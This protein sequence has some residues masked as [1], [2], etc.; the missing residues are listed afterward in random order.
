MT[1]TRPAVVLAVLCA[2]DFLVV[3][4]GLIVA[5]A[6][7]AM[8]DALGIAPSALQWVINA[9]LLGFGGLL[10][11]GG[12]LGDLYGRR[13][14]LTGG[15]VLFAAGALAG[16]LA[17][18]TAV[19]IAGRA[20]QGAA[21]ALMAPNALALLVEHFREPAERD[22]ALGRWSAVGSLGIPAGALLG[23]VITAGL[24]W[25]WVL[26]VNV[27]LAL[28]AAAAT[29]RVL[30]ESRDPGAGRRLDLPGA[31]LVTAGTTLLILAVVR[32]EAGARSVLA[33]LTGGVLLM[34]AFAAV[35]RRARAPLV[36]PGTLGAPG[37]RPALLAGAALPV[38]LGA[39]LFLGTLYLQRGLGLAPLE[40]GL[41]Y[42][43]LALP[44]IAASPAAARLS[45][46]YGARPVAVAGLLLQAA[47]LLLLARAPADGSFA[48]D[49][50]PA[51]VLVGAGAP[52][53]FVP[54]TAAIM[55]KAGEAS[56]LVSG[57]FNTAQQIGNALALAVLATIVA[58]RA[59]ALEAG[60]AAPAEALAGGLHAAFL[61]GAVLAAAACLPA[62][63]LGP[64]A[65]LRT[66]S[67]PP[68]PRR[69]RR[70]RPDPGRTAAPSRTPPR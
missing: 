24:G 43:A 45:G 50:L 62:L 47:G 5:V 29:R 70:S 16:G 48:A 25:R 23:G 55:G 8:Q 67:S 56:G 63:T 36:P 12:R 44:V 32:S 61:A 46:R 34:A 3:L 10:L 41:A 17:G 53:A 21:S 18:S 39:V 14:I 7:P 28:L 69:A 2:T 68:A 65:A 1:V 20:V 58:S 22:R 54:V 66:G 38:G 51:F 49:V 15:L 26:L 35:E 9:Y 11:L 31:V 57:V 4:D 33:P 60:G 37:R 64:R 52:I 27:P 6:L 19:L 30:E 13:R 59:A 42:L 40:T